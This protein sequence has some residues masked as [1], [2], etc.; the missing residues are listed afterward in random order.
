MAGALANTIA[1]VLAGVFLL[2]NW[3]WYFRFITIMVAPFS[4][5]TMYLLPSTQA[6]AQDLPG[7]E[8]WKRMDLGGVFILVAGLTLFI[9]GFIQAPVRGW[10]SA[11]FIAPFV[12]SIF[13]LA[14]FIVWERFMKR[15]FSLLPHDMWKYPNIFPLILQASAIFMWSAT[16]QLRIA[17]YFQDG[18][19]ISAI[20]AAVK[21]LP[22]GV[23]ALFVG[24]LTQAMPW[25]ITKPR[26]VQPIA[27]LFCFAASMLFAISGGGAGRDYWIYMFPGMLLPFALEP[28]TADRLSAQIIGTGGGMLISIGMNTSIIQAFPLEFAGQSLA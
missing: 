1:L 17:T 21:L 15:G 24:T 25:L 22:M 3:R 28:A 23:T 2:A 7:A 8:K 27:S 14:G 19:G 12:I 20:L 11:T 16:A 5:T 13:L 10:K 6:V 9:L 18:L 26:F 4:V